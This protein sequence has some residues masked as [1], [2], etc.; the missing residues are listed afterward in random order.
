MRQSVFISAI[1]LSAVLIGPAYADVSSTTL[2]STTL[3]S[4]NL[5]HIRDAIQSRAAAEASKHK[6]VR[7]TNVAASLSR[8]VTYNRDSPNPNIGWHNDGG[9]RVCHQDCDNPE[10]P[11]SGYTCK[12]VTVLGMAMRQCDS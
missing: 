8:T 4:T 3:G 9:M 12:N 6:P 11:G 7:S 2:R 5:T 1:A 10:I